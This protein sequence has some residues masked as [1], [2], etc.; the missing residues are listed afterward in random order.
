M[1]TLHL[2]V[3]SDAHA[4]RI[5][6]HS[7]RAW[8]EPVDCTDETKL[9]VTLLVS[10]LVADAVHGAATRISAGMAFDDGRLRIDVQDDRTRSGS[11]ASPCPPEWFAE[12]IADGWGRDIGAR[13]TSTWAEILC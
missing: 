12:R 2:D 5:V 10:E 1:P 4:P 3:D 6:R 8:L 11:D 13:E 9:D 7:L